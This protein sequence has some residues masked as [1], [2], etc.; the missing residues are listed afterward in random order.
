MS[1]IIRTFIILRKQQPRSRMTIPG[2]FSSEAYKVVKRP[3]STFLLYYF[4]Q[5]FCPQIC[6]LLA[7]VPDTRG[8]HKTSRS[9]RTVSSHIYLYNSRKIFPRSFHIPNRLSLKCHSQNEGTR[10]LFTA[11]QALTRTES[12]PL[13]SAATTRAEAFLS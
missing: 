8:R 4:Q 9:R 12:P 10:P 11:S 2:Q 5:S 1:L 7:T 13:D 3:S 6:P